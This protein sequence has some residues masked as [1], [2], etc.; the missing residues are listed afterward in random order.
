VKTQFFGPF[1]TKHRWILLLIF[2][3]AFGVIARAEDRRPNIVFIFADDWG[4]GDLSCHGNTQFRTPNI[5]R[6][7]AEGTDFH[8]F[9]VCNPVCSPSRTAAMTGHFPARYSVHQHFAEHELNRERG[10]PDWL[11]PKA[12]MVPRLLQQAGY[13]TGHFGKWHFTNDTIADAPHPCEYGFDVSAVFNGPAPHTKP[14]TMIDDTI[15]FIKDNKDRPFYVNVW[16]H[17]THTPHFPSPETLAANASLDEQHKVYAAVVT[18]GD[19]K[20][21]KLLDALKDLKLDDKTLVIFSSD[22]G[23]EW[24]GPESMKQLRGGLGTY[25]SVGETGGRRGR[26]RSLFEGGVHL[27]FIVRWPG[28]TPAGMK[29]DSSVIAAVDLL[30]TFCAAAGVKLPT[31][32]KPD[33]ENVLPA[34]E[35]Q[36]I[37]RTKPL[38]WEWRGTALEPDWWPRLA[39]REGNWKLLIGSDPKRRELY[40]LATDPGEQHDLAKTEADRADRMLR[41]GLDW[42]ATL[43]AVAPLDCVTKPPSGDSQTSRRPN[44]LFIL[45][46]DQRWDTIHALGNDDVKTPNLDQL[47]K[48]G[49]H[50]TNAYCMGS[51][52]PAV[53][54]P[55]RTM[56]LTGRSVWRLPDV[57]GL[58]APPEIALLPRLLHDVGYVTYHCGK[59]NNA[60]R[61]GNAA[62]DF[63]VE[64][65]KTGP[66]DMRLHGDQVVQ[67]L[68][69]H[70]RTKPFFIYLAPPVPHDPRTAPERFAKMY[71]SAKLTLSRNFMPEHPFDN[72]E[73]KIRDEQ[74][75]PWPR[76]P[77]VMRQHLAD[78]YACVSDLDD[79]VGRVLQSVRKLG[80]D[81]N[82]VVIYSS[83]QGL[84]VGG[85][86]GLMGK[87][88]LYEHVK[89]P[90]VISGPGI[91]PGHSNALVYLYDLFPSICDLADVPTPKTAE[92]MSLMPVVR[93]QAK[94]TRPY[95]FAA[96]RDFQ[97]M[98]RDDRWKLI[99]YF[100]GGQRH[101]QLFDLSTDPDE[102]RNLAEEKNNA[103]IVD[104]LRGQMRQLGREFGDPDTALYSKK[105]FKT[106]A[107]EVSPEPAQ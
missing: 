23:P 62:F 53:C 42:R 51:M 100:A 77:E 26:K 20:V 33:G 28:H 4:W 44:I 65:K 22:N 60:C 76:T 86:H 98:V 35:G 14:A 39:V 61:Y 36:P 9:A 2:Q 30:P 79:Q 10:M 68:E 48:Q 74:L 106:A 37:D 75:A 50:F 57:K 29:D 21:G 80:Y 66:D 3:I 8:K 92:G 102:L 38:F 94:V 82:T 93:R 15:K 83:D 69:K 95:L 70:D 11:D 63:N 101:T 90:L 41:L 72:G 16:L 19:R 27:P 43:P 24:T 32:Y 78:Y 25:Y 13:R 7:A 64:T 96:Y 17:E 55:S 107:K 67:F 47:V 18:D 34:L 84:A 103:D 99:E 54:L 105:A 40:D 1:M 81:E 56:L 73:L 104:R 71:D 12:V 59:S 87:Q 46:D 88:N 58:N 52:T 89:P 5:D 91:K 85:R 97:R 49:F 6:L 31:D 45:A